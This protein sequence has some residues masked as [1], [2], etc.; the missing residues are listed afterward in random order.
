MAKFKSKNKNC[1]LTVKAK[2]NK[3]E[4]IEEGQFIYFIQK[5]IRG[6]LKGELKKKNIIEYTGP[7][8]KSLE[9]YIDNPISKNDFFFIMEQIVD[10]I[11]SVFSNKLYVG[12]IV[13][14]WDQIYINEVTKEMNF[15][16]LPL[17]TPGI[18][19]DFI[20]YMEEL[21]YE[22]KPV[23][24]NDM[25]YI[26]RFVYFIKNI[27]RFDVAVIEEYIA[28]EA[29]SVVK[30]IKRHGAGQSGF[31]TDKPAHYYEHY[32]NKDNEATGLLAEEETELL[33]NEETGLLDEEATGLLVEENKTIHYATLIRTLTNEHILINKPVFRVGKEPT[34]SDYRVTNNNKVSRSHADIITKDNH[35]YIRD[36]NSKNG[37]YI[38]RQMI[39]VQQEVEIFDGNHITLANEEFEFHI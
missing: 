26:S 13:W 4:K 29:P 21:A 24:E 10:V 11:Q 15:I 19:P 35:Y 32:D 18:E 17:E 5:N 9:E 3:K 27:N 33:D 22:I 2:L 28:K 20:R 7:V 36:L 25:G 37:T 31:M 6:T 14:E 8:A 16:Y 30:I 1:L 34:Y 39:P 23:Q 12:N 38:N